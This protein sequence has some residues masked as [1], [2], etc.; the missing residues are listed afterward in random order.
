[1]EYAASTLAS[2][3]LPVVESHT[4]WETNTVKGPASQKT[5][6]GLT[7]VTIQSIW[8]P[9][10]LLSD[11]ILWPIIR[12]SSYRFTLEGFPQNRAVKDHKCSF[13]RSWHDLAGRDVVDIH[14]ANDV[15]FA[16]AAAFHIGIEL[17]FQSIVDIIPEEGRVN[18]DLAFK[19]SQEEHDE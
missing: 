10:K 16:I 2:G 12:E 3:W 15:V 17:I 14:N 18:V 4:V 6:C 1:M 7:P 19:V 9:S 11:R 13:S 5:P 8:K